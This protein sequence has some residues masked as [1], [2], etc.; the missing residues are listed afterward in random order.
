MGSFKFIFAFAIALLLS[1]LTIHAECTN[2][3][4]SGNWFARQASGYRFEM[5]L[6]QEG[7]KITGDIV[8]YSGGGRG[9]IESGSLEGSNLGLIV[10]WSSEDAATRSHNEAYLGTINA[11]GIIEGNGIV[12]GSRSGKMRWSSDTKMKCLSN[13]T[14]VQKLGV[15]RTDPAQTP[16]PANENTQPWIRATPIP[17]GN[18]AVLTWD[19][20]KDHPYAEVWVKVNGAAETFVV[21]QGKGG[22][23][24]ALPRG[25]T[26]TYILTDSGKTLAT[27]TIR[28]N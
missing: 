1:S 25:M 24:V 10:V 20:G 16:A 17:I 12:F 14:P 4:I 21:E 23:E 27:T 8:P 11:S 26:F 7:A 22:R 19:A 9:V 15:K 5:R 18:K 2:W 28:G 6:K 13:F 3:D